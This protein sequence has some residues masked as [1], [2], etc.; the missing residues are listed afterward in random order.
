[1]FKSI[2]SDRITLIWLIVALT[3]AAVLAFHKLAQPA[4][5]I[6]DEAIYAD[7]TLD[8]KNTGKLFVLGWDGQYNLYNTKPPL[9]IWMQVVAMHV[10][11]PGEFAV[12]FPSALAGLLTCLVILL[13]SYRSLGDIRIGIVAV[14]VLMSCLG[15]VRPH[16]IRSGDLDALLVLWTTMYSCVVLHYILHPGF[17]V[18]RT[19][20]LAGL[21]VVLAF[22]TKSVAG[23]IPLAGLALASGYSGVLREFL[24]SKWTY[25]VL[26]VAIL[27]CAGYYVIRES[28]LPGY[29][30]RVNYSEYQRFYSNIMPWHAHP[31]YYYLV[32]FVRLDL[33]TP[34]IWL[35]P[36]AIL[37]SYV[38]GGTIKSMTLIL[39]WI[40]TFLLILSVP[41]NKLQWY[42]APVYPFLAIVLGIGAVESIHLCRDKWNFNPRLAFSV[43]MLL[44]LVP[45]YGM[46][47]RNLDRKTPLDPLEREGYS[48]RALHSLEKVPADLKVLMPVHT[49]AHRTQVDFY[50]VLLNRYH[51]YNIEILDSAGQVRKGHQVLCCIPAQVEAVHSAFK[52]D[53]VYSNDVGCVWLDVGDTVQ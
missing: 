34:F 31:W 33:F 15:F 26:G 2:L 42:E 18:R 11:G 37:A 27:L 14:V 30:D 53:T 17:G 43:V 22:Y 20:A 35:V 49:N 21:A 1:M 16:V 5:F 29:M 25:I 48:L 45:A 28:L 52:A 24:K 8:M 40:V 9:A 10:F 46:F 38:R 50:R 41:P 23:F 6:W 51:G 32:N 4:I 19:V 39:I 36:P 12:R 3:V 7:N 44:L 47:Q 13:F